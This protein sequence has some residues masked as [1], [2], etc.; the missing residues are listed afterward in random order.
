MPLPVFKERRFL[1]MLN[2]F[3]QSRHTLQHLGTL[4]C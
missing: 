4:M 1:Y 2:G 3:I